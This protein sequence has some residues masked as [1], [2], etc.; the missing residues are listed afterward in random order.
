MEWDARRSLSEDLKV[1]L[2]IDSD[3]SLYPSTRHGL[4]EGEYT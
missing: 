4:T 3:D 1:S 2:R